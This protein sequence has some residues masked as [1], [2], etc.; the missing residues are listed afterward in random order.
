MFGFKRMGDPDLRA[1]RKE[2]LRI[3]RENHHLRC[4]NE[5]LVKEMSVLREEMRRLQM[6]VREYQQMLFKKKSLF[7]KKDKNDDD[8]TPRKKGPPIGHKGT[9]REIP[10]KVDEHKDV[11]L[12]RCPE[13]SSDKLTPCAGYYD[14]Y[15][16]DIV[17]P[18]TKVTRFRHHYYWCPNC[19]KTVHGAGIGELPGSY[20]GPNAKA[21]AAKGGLDENVQAMVDSLL[22]SS[23]HRFG[24]YLESLRRK[25]H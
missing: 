18:E 4:K 5:S 13:C 9:T 7:H 2:G 25:G 23:E 12:D 11:H 24:R 19:K 8:H 20:I 1:L 16:E 10:K 22:R 3:V 21:L 14:H 6:I 15:Q 17:I